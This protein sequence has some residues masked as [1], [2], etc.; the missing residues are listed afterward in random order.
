MRYFQLITPI[1][2][3][4]PL[5]GE[6]EIYKEEKGVQTL[7]FKRQIIANYPNE[8]MEIAHDI[9]LED[10][11]REKKYFKFMVYDSITSALSKIL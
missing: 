4:Y 6:K 1:S 7:L 11:Q 9:S 10:V 5:V 8:Q 2:G 3:H